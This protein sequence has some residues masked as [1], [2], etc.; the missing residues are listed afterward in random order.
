MARERSHVVGANGGPG[1]LATWACLL[2]SARTGPLE[3]WPPPPQQ[4][5]RAL[6]QL[7]KFNHHTNIIMAPALRE[8]HAA[9][10]SCPDDLRQVRGA[11][12]CRLIATRA[13]LRELGLLPE[14]GAV[15]LTVNNGES[16]DQLFT[17]V[18]QKGPDGSR[19]AVFEAAYADLAKI[20]AALRGDEAP[21]IYTAFADDVRSLASPSA[22]VLNLEC[23]GCCSEYG[24]EGDDASKAGLWAAIEACL[25][26]GSFVMA[27]DFSLKAIIKDW[28][29]DTLGPLPFVQIPSASCST[30]FDLAFD[31]EALIACPSAQL[32][33]VGQL[34]ADGKASSHAMG[35]TIVYG[36]DETAAAAAEAAGVQL[37][38]LTVAE[39]IDGMVTASDGRFKQRLSSVANGGTR[40]VAGHVLLT[41]P[42]GGRLL[43][44]MGHWVELSKLHG[45]TEESVLR[46]ARSRGAG[47][48]Q[49]IKE[50]LESCADDTARSRMLQQYAAELVQNSAPS[51]MVQNNAGGLCFEVD[52]S[53]Q[54]LRFLILGSTSG[55][56]YTSAKEATVKN[57]GSLVRLMEA[58]KGPEAVGTIRSVSVE[59]R[60]S[61]QT[62]TLLALAMC[63]Q[64]GDPATKK[65]A[66]ATL[67]DIC[68]TPTMLFEFLS[69]GEMVASTKEGGGTG[70]GRAHRRAVSLWYNQYRGSSPKALAEAV[71]KFQNRGG[72]SHLDALR[73][74]HA[75]PA[76]PGHS[77]VFRYLAKGLDAAAEVAASGTA[78]P[79]KENRKKRAL[80]DAQ[81]AAEAPTVVL[82]YLSAVEEA[83]GL[84]SDDAARCVALVEEHRLAREHVPT[85]LLNSKE[86]WRA[87]LKAMPL[88][89][90]LRNLAKLTAIGLLEKLPGEPPSAEV[91]SVVS[92]LTN[93]TAVTKARLH[94]LAVLLAQRTYASGHG[95][96]G[97]LEWTPI[98][99]VTVA[100]EAAFALSFAAVK[101]AGKRFCVALDISE[102]MSAPISGG[103]GASLTCAEAAAAMALLIAKTEPSCTVMAFAETFMPLGITADMTLPEAVG[104]AAQ[105]MQTV[106]PGG[107]DCSMPMQWALREMVNAKA[108]AQ[109]EAATFDCFLVFTDNETWSGELQ[110]VDALARYRKVSRATDAKLITV[111]MASNG[112]SV[113]DPEDTGML[114]VVGFD[115]SA[116]EV[117]S[118]FAAGR[119]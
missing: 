48:A 35:G 41:Y 109:I 99:E 12:P 61:R 83:K 16:Y 101:P 32:N 17:T 28:K 88:N 108:P 72:W 52:D 106:R 84:G 77:V 97:S 29:P 39:K 2:Q 64:L 43:A 103:G 7:S 11:A 79:P 42:S 54:L 68:R 51:A 76:S 55:T 73:L 115:T 9:G 107:T 67:S 118:S 31:P 96:K 57:L 98:A 113:A 105:L 14:V 19:V 6:Q 1:S 22:F 8:V 33:V 119:I 21:A 36:V 56:Y 95:D 20:V 65:V 74:C 30:S 4:T 81:P 13:E 66:Y 46:A 100:L 23:C 86:V 75:T 40:G 78:T 34:C 80:E 60:A 89:A 15:V 24:F 50:E 111:G 58:G 69:M 49:Q 71:T 62:P 116:P 93:A 70:W 45:C 117:I 87:M 53:T 27:S 104:A 37:E 91:A 59:G 94:P 5:H 110:P 90:L 25:S 18:Q 85:Q 112:F 63:C 10:W 44:S 82:D 26:R 47:Y 38:V 3:P 92:K 102:S 114:D